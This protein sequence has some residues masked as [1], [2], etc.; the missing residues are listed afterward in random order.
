M[1]S[2]TF[3][4]D[5]ELS[6]AHIEGLRKVAQQHGIRLLLVFGSAVTG[7]LHARSDLD[8]AVLTEKAGLSWGEIA[9]L[10]ADL[11]AAIPRVRI[12]MV[13]LYQ[14]DPLLLKNIA[15]NCRLLVGGANELARFKVYAYKRWVDHRRFFELERQ[16]TEDWVQR[17][18]EKH[19]S[20]P[21]AA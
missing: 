11:Q 16:W 3:D 19:K 1:N 10:L 17:Q 20:A 8:L 5:Y 4:Q 2:E 7:L 9:D 14:A 15:D 21:G 12:D 13:L 18:V 6:P